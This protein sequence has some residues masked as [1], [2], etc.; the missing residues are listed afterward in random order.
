MIQTGKGGAS[1]P[2]GTARIFGLA[3]CAARLITGTAFHKLSGISAK[4]G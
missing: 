1:R 3:T 2:T 4:T